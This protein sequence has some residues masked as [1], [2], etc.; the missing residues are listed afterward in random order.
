MYGRGEVMLRFLYRIRHLP[1]VTVIAVIFGGSL[2]LVGVF[3]VYTQIVLRELKDEARKTSRTFARLCPQVTRSETMGPVI[4]DEIV[5]GSDFPRIIT[6]PIGEIQSWK[7]TGVDPTDTTFLSRVK[8]FGEL[9]RMKSLYAPIP[10]TD[11]PSGQILA[12]LHYGDSPRV[13]HLTLIPYIELVFFS[14]FLIVIYWV[15]L[16]QRRTEQRILWM[17]LAKETAHQLGTPITSLMGWLQLLEA[18]AQEETYKAAEA[19]VPPELRLYNIVNA[20]QS[21]TAN[22][23]KIAQRFSKIGSIPELEATSVNDLL[24]AIVYYF[25]RRVPLM[26]GEVT[27]REN[28]LTLPFLKANP[29]LL[30]WAFENVIRNAVDSL[31]A[32]GGGQLEILTKLEKGGRAIQVLISDNGKG[33]SATNWEK[34]FEAGYTTKSRGWG[35]GLTLTRRIVEEYHQGKIEIIESRPME[36]T[37]FRFEL[38]GII[39]EERD[40]GKRQG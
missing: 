20:M 32:S 2:L 39:P 15:L 19:E 34:V 36:R 25:R 31:S 24:R 21:D 13:L 30:T 10:I 12:Y 23:N 18:Q 8:L 3:F 16:N 4:F 29:E 7:A 35:L 26:E 6:S 33:V 9:Q 28:Y 40:G 38:P 11:E 14:F 27:F 1:N 37:T 17:G 5:L 22:L